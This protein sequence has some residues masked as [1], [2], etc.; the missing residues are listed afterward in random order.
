VL[1]ACEAETSLSEG[2]SLAFPACEL[3]RRVADELLANNRHAPPPQAAG[4]DSAGMDV[5]TH[6]I[7]RGSAQCPRAFLELASFY[8]HS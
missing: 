1:A 6:R 4:H 3:A 8:R 5:A 7:D 2:P